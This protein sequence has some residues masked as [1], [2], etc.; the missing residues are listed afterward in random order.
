[1]TDTIRTQAEL[2]AFLHPNIGNA[3]PNATVLQAQAARDLIVSLPTLLG[4]APL[5]FGAGVDQFAPGLGA[6]GSVLNLLNGSDLAPYSGDHPTLRVARQELMTAPAHP[7]SAG[8]SAA[9]FFSVGSLAGN[10]NQPNALF[11]YALGYAEGVNYLIGG[12]FLG[13]QTS[14][15]LVA[16]SKGGGLGLS[17]AGR[18]T[19]VGGGAVAANVGVANDTGVDESYNATVGVM[20]MVGLDIFSYGANKAGAG[21]TFRGGAFDV[22]LGFL[23]GDFIKAADFRTDDQ[24][25]TVFDLRGS[26]ANLWDSSVA[27]VSGDHIKLTSG[28]RLGVAGGNPFLAFDTGDFILFSANTYNF[29]IASAVALVISAS[30]TQ[31]N[32]DLQHSGSKL[33]LYN[34]PPISKQTGVPV[35]AAGIHAACVAAGLFA[36]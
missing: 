24:S 36:A 27:T 25:P 19:V 28:Y 18:T 35:T 4:I 17:F 13:E 10:K 7:L 11:G 34:T 21:I 8:F 23:A 30:A 12:N 20:K 14:G 26:H 22:G 6:A 1:M 31:I 9:G 15:A 32:G 3:A 5:T 33:G 2:L 29:E 16:G